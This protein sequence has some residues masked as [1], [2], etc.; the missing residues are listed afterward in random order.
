M[1]TEEMKK[2]SVSNLIPVV[3]FI[4]GAAFKNKSSH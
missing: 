2:D 1:K 3:P 4:M